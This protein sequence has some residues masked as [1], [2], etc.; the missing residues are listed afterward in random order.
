MATAAP[1]AQ[2]EQAG[3]GLNLASMNL[4]PS[5]SA[6]AVMGVRSPENKIDLGLV[7]EV[8][9]P[10]DD[11]VRLDIADKEEAISVLSDYDIVMDATTISLNDISTE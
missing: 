9:D 10:R 5:L 2:L 1:R 6:A 4:E 11:Y 3:P 7:D 8:G